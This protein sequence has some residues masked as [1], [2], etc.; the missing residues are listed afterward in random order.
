MNRLR[1]AWLNARDRR[2]GLLWLLSLFLVGLGARQ[3]LTS[4]QG[5]RI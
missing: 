3:G 5:K 1:A 4:D 2:G